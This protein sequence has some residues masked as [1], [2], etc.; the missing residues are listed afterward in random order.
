MSTDP[1]CADFKIGV[2]L[3]KMARLPYRRIPDPVAATYNEFSVRATRGNKSIS[4]HGFPVATWEWNGLSR[5]AIYNLLDFF[6]SSASANVYIRTLV[7][8]R[9]NFANF[10]AVMARPELA[11]TDGRPADSLA[12]AFSTVVI[13]F[14]GLIAQ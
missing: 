13:R 3:A 6:G 10:Y 8:T 9:A 11:G 1:I 2:T 7:N 4:G 14:T 5:V 12:P